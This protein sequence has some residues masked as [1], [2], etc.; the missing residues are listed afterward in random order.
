MA[1]AKKLNIFHQYCVHSVLYIQT[2]VDYQMDLYLEELERAIRSGELNVASESARGLAN[3]K[4][5]IALTCS[6]AT[7]LPERKISVK[8]IIEDRYISDISITLN[9][10]PSMKFEDLKQLV[11][12]KFEFPVQVQQWIAGKRLARDNDTLRS[13]GIRQDND[14][15]YLYLVSASSVGL[16]KQVL[17]T[18]PQKTHG[19]NA[20]IPD[21]QLYTTDIQDLATGWQC[22]TCTLI[23]EPTRPGC[24]VCGGSRPEEYIVPADYELSDN[25]RLRMEQEISFENLAIMERESNF[26]RHLA[27]EE[28]DLIANTDEFDCPVCFERIGRLEGV[29]LRE[30]LH[31]FCKECLQS[32]VLHAESAVVSCPYVE[33]SH[34]CLSIIQEREIKALVSDEVYQKHLTLSLTE[35]ESRAANSFHCQ[36]PNC[37]GWCIYEDDVNTFECSVCEKENCLTCKAIHEGVSCRHYQ[38]DVK[39]KAKNDVAAKR[40]QQKIEAMLKKGDAMKCP[41]CDIIVMKKDGC[42]WIRCTMCKTEIC[43]VTK[44]PRWGPMGP[45][46]VSGGCR[47]GIDDKPCHPNCQNCH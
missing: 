15:L 5:N 35:A 17:Q 25:E 26:Q 43:W 33:G 40:T 8:V 37:N 12:E 47:C 11:L 3:L 6:E 32:Q 10:Y 42:D 9:L 21:A 24:S 29:M 41:T 30:C 22:P 34:L 14:V 27:A 1:D 39:H 19:F 20:I 44:G 28:S 45:D 18:Q 4:A 13:C 7:Y 36:T 46:D 38:N 16:D 2:S 23:N 31:M